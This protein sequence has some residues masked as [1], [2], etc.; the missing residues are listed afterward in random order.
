MTSNLLRVVPNKICISLLLLIA[1]EEIKD[2]LVTQKIKLYLYDGPTQNE[3]F[4]NLKDELSKLK[5]EPLNLQYQVTFHDKILYT[6]T[7]NT[8]GYPSH[9]AIS[10]AKLVNKSQ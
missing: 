8:F 9:T 3:A 7:G 4:I 2:V 6:F 10:N 5:T 1:I